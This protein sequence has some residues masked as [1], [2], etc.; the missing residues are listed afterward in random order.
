[1]IKARQK[2]LEE[3]YNLIKSYS[4]IL[5]T[6][7]GGCTSVCLAGGQRETLLLKEELSELSR[8]QGKKKLICRFL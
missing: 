2:P 5:C 7:C 6:G 8:D 3:I 1:M 4:R